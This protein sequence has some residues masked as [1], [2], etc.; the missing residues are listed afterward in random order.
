MNTIKNMPVST[1]G[2]IAFAL[3]AFIAIST[4]AFIF[5]QAT[6]S[7][8]LVYENLAL[9]VQ[10]EEVTLLNNLVTSANLTIKQFLLTGDR[11]KVADYNVI[12]S[13]F[14]E[15][16]TKLLDEIKIDFPQEFTLLS[17]ANETLEKWHLDFVDN[18]INLMRKPM[19][20]DRARAMDLTGTGNEL[21]AK[22]M[23]S[24]LHFRN[25]LTLHLPINFRH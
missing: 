20:V 13:E 10:Q 24:M 21:L 6:K 7:K 11:E 9:I 3:L 8:S 22:S 5:M 16:M 23:V 17:K 25:E 14:S 19:T 12:K 4:S 2:F 18:Q 15:H 1:K